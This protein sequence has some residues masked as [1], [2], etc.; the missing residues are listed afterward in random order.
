MTTT[1]IKSEI[2]NVLDNIPE[3]VL[4]DVLDFF[5][6]LQG[7]SVEKIKLTNHLRQT[8]VED[9]ELLERLAQ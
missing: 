8:L 4:Q 7:Q 5:R 2:Q 6:E 3:S 9:K 1:E